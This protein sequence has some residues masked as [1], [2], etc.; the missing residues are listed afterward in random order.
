[1]GRFRCFILLLALSLI[2]STAVAEL[3]V[4]VAIA[5]QKYL[6]ERIAGSRVRVLL[7]V[8]PGQSVETYEPTP[9]LM[10]ELGTVRLYLRI[11]LPFETVWLSKVEGLYPAMKVVDVAIGIERLPMG[12]HHHGEGVPQAHEQFDPHIWL[13]PKLLM[14][15]AANM[16]DALIA[17]DPAEAAGYRQGYSE[18]AQELTALDQQL[19]TLLAAR[20]GTAFMVYHPAFGYFAE[21]YGLRQIAIEREGKFPGARS[22]AQLI[23]EGKQARVRLILAEQQTDRRLAE[24]VAGSLGA[25]VVMVDH[26]TENVPDTLRQLGTLLAEPSP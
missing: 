7:V 1:M 5:P 12:E 9:R 22:L 10:S 8:P 6:L 18:L 17:A 2:G 24:M 16:R 25:R 21:A 11:G 3:Q 4:A 26:L 19:A 20:R 14:T 23:E 13:A 15:Q